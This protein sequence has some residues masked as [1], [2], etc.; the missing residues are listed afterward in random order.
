MTDLSER[1]PGFQL[2]TLDR[3]VET[4]NAIRARPS[5]LT[6]TELG[7]SLGLPKTSV[8]RLLKAMARHDFVRK[9]ELTKTYRLGPA[10]LV[11]GADSLNQWDVRSVAHGYLEQLV[12]V[13]NETGCLAVMHEDMAFCLDTIESARSAPFWVRIGKEMEWHCA[14]AGKAI[15]AYQPDSQVDRILRHRPLQRF[16]EHTITDVDE[17]KVHLR[18]V[19]AQGYA[20]CDGELEIGVKAIGVPVVQGDSSVIGSVTLIAPSERLD[21]RGMEQLLPQLARTAQQISMQLGHHPSA[22]TAARFP[23]DAVAVSVPESLTASGPRGETNTRSGTQSR[24]GPRPSVHRGAVM[25]E[26][27]QIQIDGGRE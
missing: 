23:Q 17:L 4:L 9:D 21:A 12:R 13:T 25:D 15:L 18:Q 10:L 5:G 24:D 20:V 26:V 14:A 27:A 19:R 8:H 7:S 22:L 1:T 3:I 2:Q 16:T 6:L 11:L